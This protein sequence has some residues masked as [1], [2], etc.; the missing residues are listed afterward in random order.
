MNVAAAVKFLL[1]SPPIR[2]EGMIITISRS[3]IRNS[4]VIV[5]NCLENLFFPPLSFLN[6]HSNGD[7]PLLLNLSPFVDNA[8]TKVKSSLRDIDVAISFSID[9]E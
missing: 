2:G 6:P 8:I 3:N 4:R 5:M 7:F 1:F 9:I